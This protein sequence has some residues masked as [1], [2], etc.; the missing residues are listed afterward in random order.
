MADLEVSVLPMRAVHMCHLLLKAGHEVAEGRLVICVC[1]LSLFKGRR[2]RVLLH[3]VPVYAVCRLHD[4]VRCVGLI[5]IRAVVPQAVSALAAGFHDAVAR[6]AKD[7][8]FSSAGEGC[9]NLFGFGRAAG[10]PGRIVEGVSPL[11][12]GHLIPGA[13]VSGSYNGVRSGGF[14]KLRRI[15]H[16]HTADL[17]VCAGRRRTDMSAANLGSLECMA[18]KLR[19][20]VAKAAVGDIAGNGA[21]CFCGTR[22]YGGDGFSRKHRT[23]SGSYTAKNAPDKADA[24]AHAH[25]RA[26]INDG[27]TDIA[28]TLE[29]AG[30]AGCKAAGRGAGSGCSRTAPAEHAACALCAV[31][32]AADHPCGHQQLHAHAGTGLRH[33]KSHGG[34]IAVEFLRGL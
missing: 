25:A 31:S 5:V 17:A 22:C 30:K 11:S 34:H 14:F 15:E 20:V 18:R 19:H 1:G 9:C 4:S 12:A 24:A 7:C 13:A 10:K 29:S 28:V 6:V 33:I 23:V 3:S 16:F 27:V 21:G 8:T 32:H 2:F 26:A